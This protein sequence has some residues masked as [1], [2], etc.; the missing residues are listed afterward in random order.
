[1]IKKSQ[2]KVRSLLQDSEGSGSEL[3]SEKG[4]VYE[5]DGKFFQIVMVAQ[6]YLKLY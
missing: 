2:A 6:I 5:L 3:S 1:M 4:N